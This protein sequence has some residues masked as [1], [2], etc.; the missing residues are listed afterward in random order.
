MGTVR[1]EYV[2]P[3]APSSP[4]GPGGRQP[5][6]AVAADPVV[7]HHPCHGHQPGL[8][9]W[10][11]RLG[12]GEA[13]ARPTAGPPMWRQ[14]LGLWGGTEASAVRAGVTALCPAPPTGIPAP[15]SAWAPSAV[16]VCR[17]PVTISSG[18]ACHTCC[19][20]GPGVLP[21]AAPSPAGILPDQLRLSLS[22]GNLGA[23]H[24]EAAG[25]EGCSQ[26]G[27]GQRWA[28]STHLSRLPAQLTGIGAKAEACGQFPGGLSSL[29]AGGRGQAAPRS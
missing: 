24:T 25:P 8:E 13:G 23:N 18:P 27:R 20:P 5:P 7:S 2:K 17:V 1:P 14:G 26:A 11:V 4:Q 12:G 28:L 10:A 19:L 9:G 16:A 15:G 21:P 22:G 6:C 3:L 29:W